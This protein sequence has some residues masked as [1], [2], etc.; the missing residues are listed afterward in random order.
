MNELINVVIPTYNRENKIKKCI[1]SVLNQTYQNIELIIVDDGSIDNT[2]SVIE[3]IH[4]SRIKYVYQPNAGACVARNSGIK[5]A[6]GNYIALQ[7]SDDEWLPE[8]LEIQMKAMEEK[9]ADVVISKLNRKFANSDKITIIPKR[10]SGEVHITDDF[11]GCGTQTILAKKE[12]FDDC[13][14]DR[15][16]PRL[17]DFE[18]MYRVLQK[19]KVYCV[20]TPL[21]NYYIGD[22]SIV[23][24]PEKRYQATELFL[25]KHPDAKKKSPKIM[26]HMAK[27]LIESYVKECKKSETKYIKLAF[28]CLPV[29][30]TK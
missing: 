24:N 21:V 29:V 11:Y 1:E 26:T 14:F 27:D 15:E 13:L 8:K 12:V 5:M 17:Q 9:N 30:K 4:D 20:D 7:D 3:D 22:D 16:F 28:K 19:Y 25:K 6:K 18:W 2:A 10:I 23:S